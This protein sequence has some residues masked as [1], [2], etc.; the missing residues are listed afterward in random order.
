M[1]IRY[2]SCFLLCILVSFSVCQS[3]ASFPYFENFDNSAGGWFTGT[4]NFPKN[5]N[6]FIAIYN[7][8]L[9][10]SSWVLGSP[11][12]SIISSTHSGANCWVTKVQGDY[13]ANEQYVS[14]KIFFFKHKRSFV[15]SPSFDFSAFVYDPIFVAWIAYD[16]EPLWDGVCLRMSFNGTFTTLGYVDDGFG[17]YN[18]NNISNSVVKKGW[19][20]QTVWTRVSHILTGNHWQPHKYPLCQVL[21]AS[22]TLRCASYLPVGRNINT[23]ALLLTI[24]P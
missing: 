9:S 21:Q 17:W 2:V 13:N 15:Q 18:H 23:K 22:Q 7:T 6:K 11:S 19:D 5:S 16:L 24:F 14:C 1:A 20:S 8:S 3:V 12:K 4:N 10:N